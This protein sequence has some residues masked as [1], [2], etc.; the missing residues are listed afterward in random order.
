[1][2]STSQK[3]ELTVDEVVEEYVGSFGFSQIVTCCWFQFHGFLMPKTLGYH[4][5]GRSTGGGS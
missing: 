2:E 5:Y 4:F 1:M 3:L